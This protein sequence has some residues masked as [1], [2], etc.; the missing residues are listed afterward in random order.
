[1]PPPHTHT[2]TTRNLPLAC[3]GLNLGSGVRCAW[4]GGTGA[5]AGGGDACQAGM[6]GMQRVPGAHQSRPRPPNVLAGLLPP[7][8]EACCLGCVGCPQAPPLR[9][10][11]GGVYGELKKKPSINHVV[12]IV[13]WGEEDGVP[14]WI[15]R[16]SWGEPWGEGG[17]MR[18]V[19]SEYEGGAYSLGIEQ[20]C[21]FAVPDGCV[22]GCAALGWAGG[23]GASRGLGA[24]FETLK[25]GAATA[26]PGRGGGDAYA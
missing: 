14:Y 18:L 24:C 10:P 1:M 26:D 22:A 7:W 5:E 12:S 9:R 15:V 23:T 21:S 25:R 3:V 6:P 8:L 17:F 16:N 2:H 20:E 19:T 13:G 11:A 4:V